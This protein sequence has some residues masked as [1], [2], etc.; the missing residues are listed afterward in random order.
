VHT[1]A[2]IIDGCRTKQRELQ[3]ALYLRYYGTMYAVCLRYA[4]NR[5]EA[6]DILQ[7]GFI[8]VFNNIKQ[9]AGSGSFQGWIRRIMINSALELIQKRKLDI[10]DFYIENAEDSNDSVRSRI[11]TNDLLEI[12]E[13]LPKGYRTV[14]NLYAIQGY[15]HKEIAEMLNVSEGTSKSQ[16]ARARN[17]LQAKL[18]RLN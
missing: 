10:T 12:I 7:E 17:L 11:D 2:E 18:K 5:Y 16:F 15:Q 14:F 9:F 4:K 6:E 13:E 1:E 3:K 8:K